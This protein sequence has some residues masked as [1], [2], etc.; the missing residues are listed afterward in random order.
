MILRAENNLTSIST[1][2]FLSVNE[3]PIFHPKNLTGWVWMEW[4]KNEI[5]EGPEG[6]DTEN[7]AVFIE[8]TF[9]ITMLLDLSVLNLRAAIP[10]LDCNVAIRFGHLSKK[11]LD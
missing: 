7:G 9:M 5:S 2:D 6:S 3:P 11:R 8:L 1:I 4:V 10:E